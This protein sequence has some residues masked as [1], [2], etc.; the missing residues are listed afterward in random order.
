M[1]KNKA[2]LVVGFAFYLTTVCTHADQVNMQNGDRFVGKVVTVSNETVVVQSDV[3][4]I[5]L[6]PRS[7]IATIVLGTN[8]VATPVQAPVVA[9]APPSPT[10]S[11]SNERQSKS[12]RS[13]STV[14]DR[15]ECCSA[16][17]EAGATA[18]SRRSRPASY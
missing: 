1:S 3:L 6:V 4:G 14:T 5:L 12:E 13:H 11:H 16:G 17:S 15:H 10:R 18:N 9:G 7:K 2:R 8:A